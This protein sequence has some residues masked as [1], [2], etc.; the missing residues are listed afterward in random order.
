MAEVGHRRDD[1]GLLGH[2]PGDRPGGRHGLL[3]RPRSELPSMPAY[4]TSSVVAL[5]PLARRLYSPRCPADHPAM[6]AM[7]MNMSS[8]MMG[9][10]NAATPFGLEGHG[11][12]G[13]PQHPA[14]RRHQRH[15]S[16]P[17]DQYQRDHYI[18]PLRNHRGAPGRGLRGPLGDLDSYPD[19]DDLLHRGGGDRIFCSSDVSP[20]SVP[21]P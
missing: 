9:L 7:V 4:A 14:G 3:P 15:G 1:R 18:P 2:H 13:S 17:R 8:N 20:F 12:S 10:G 11:R 19:R 5:A 21:G 16:L 6:G